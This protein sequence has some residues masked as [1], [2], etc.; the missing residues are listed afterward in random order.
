MGLAAGKTQ[1]GWKEKV[2]RETSILESPKKTCSTPTD[3]Q[4]TPSTHGRYHPIRFGGKKT[5]ALILIQALVALALKPP[6]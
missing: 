1:A 2:R 3:H 5:V 6:L 4:A